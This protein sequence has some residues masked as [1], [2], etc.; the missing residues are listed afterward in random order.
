MKNYVTAVTTAHCL[1][2]ASLMAWCISSN[3]ASPRITFRRQNGGVKKAFQDMN[4]GTSRKPHDTLKRSKR[5][6]LDRVIGPKHRIA[7]I[8]QLRAKY[9][10]GAMRSP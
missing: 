4:A 8:D 10:A 6:R 5:L 2:E 7:R 1:I 9:R 3:Y